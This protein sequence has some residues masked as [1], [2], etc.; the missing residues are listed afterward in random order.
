MTIVTKSILL[1]TTALILAGIAS[2]QSL[3]ADIPFAFRA[4]GKLM[5][6]GAYTITVL[7]SNSIEVYRLLNTEQR[8]SVAVLGLVPHD[9]DRQ[10]RDD[11][12][13]RLTFQCGDRNCVLAEFWTGVS[14]HPSY[15]F[16][17]PK[18]PAEALH[19]AVVTARP[20]P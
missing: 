12:K 20:M 4:S 7:N 1:A 19:I 11:G 14:G 8:E 13:P 17:V 5:Q 18:A 10:W 16:H 15:R 6:P 9:A 3:H 2:A